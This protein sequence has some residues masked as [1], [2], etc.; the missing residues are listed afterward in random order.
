MLMNRTAARTLNGMLPPLKSLR[1]AAAEEN[2]RKKIRY[3]VYLFESPKPGGNQMKFIMTNRMNGGT[4]SS[5]CFLFSRNIPA[6]PMTKI[7]P[8][9]SSQNTPC[10]RINV[11]MPAPAEYHTGTVIADET[12]LPPRDWECMYIISTRDTA[13]P[14]RPNSASSL[15]TLL[16]FAPFIV[17]TR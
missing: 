17:R 1:S 2:P 10:S 14:T 12:M 9:T 3:T 5:S 15:R 16:R 13:S 6:I 8:K 11:T 4:N 7:E